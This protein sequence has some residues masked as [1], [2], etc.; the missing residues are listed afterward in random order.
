[1]DQ[2]QFETLARQMA[3]GEGTRRAV[4]RLLAGGALAGLEARLGFIQIATASNSLKRKR[5]AEQKPHGQLVAA[6]KHKKKRRK[7]QAA[8]VG[9]GAEHRQC[10]DGACIA[11]D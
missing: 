9:C 4:M 3:G 1:M 7:K 5:Q 6:G 10:A 8:P 11:L 2:A